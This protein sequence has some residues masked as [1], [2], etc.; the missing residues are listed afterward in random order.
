MPTPVDVEPEVAPEFEVEV[1]SA[2]AADAEQ[3]RMTHATWSVLFFISISPENMSAK[4]NEVVRARH[5]RLI[6]VSF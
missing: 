3:K 2:L 6:G 1:V 4:F 5:I